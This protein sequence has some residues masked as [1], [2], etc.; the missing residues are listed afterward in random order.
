MA[1]QVSMQFGSP[2]A[3]SQNSGSSGGGGS[4]IRIMEETGTISG[5][6]SSGSYKDYSVTFSQAFPSVPWVSIEEESAST[7][8][9][10]GSHAMTFPSSPTETGFTIRFFNNTGARRYPTIKWHAMLVISGS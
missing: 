4:G 6:I 10:Y 5:D 9:Q 3:V 8:Y 7:A 1:R 2:G